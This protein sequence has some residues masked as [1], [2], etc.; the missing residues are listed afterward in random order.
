MSL[1]EAELRGSE[2]SDSLLAHVQGFHTILGIP[3][4]PQGECKE[5]ATGGRPAGMFFKIIDKSRGFF[6]LYF[7]FADITDHK[8]PERTTQAI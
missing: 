1:F 5:T 7:L 8:T 2:A 3:I 4:A 6:I